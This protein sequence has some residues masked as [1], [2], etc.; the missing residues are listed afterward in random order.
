M[1]GQIMIK[2]LL[3]EDDE[4]LGYM[5]KGSLED[6]IGGYEVVHV[7]DGK[8]GLKAWK[9]FSPDII[10]SDIEMPVMDGNEMVRIIRE[11][12]GDTPIFF[13]TAKGSP[14]DVTTGYRSGVNNYIK[15]PFLPEELNAHIQALIKLKN[16]MKM[17][18]ENKI[19]KLGNYC[20]DA[21]HSLL[22]LNL[23]DRILT[24]RETKILQLLCK[25]KG[26][27]VKREKILE[28]IWGESNFYTSRSLDVFAKKLRTYLSEDP[29][30]SIRTV[31]GIGL[32]LID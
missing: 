30:V 15:K 32:M 14:K 2:L 13:A 31:K 1:N 20:F 8:E 12:D 11:A 7:L 10:V 17:R 5:I 3:V 27:T 18:D 21:E 4:N 6:M 23:Q 24:M 28:D 19:F 26:D 25:N 29:S 22:Q 9:E 16:G